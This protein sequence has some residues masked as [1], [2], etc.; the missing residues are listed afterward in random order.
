VKHAICRVCLAFAASMIPPGPLGAKR[1]QSRDGNDRD[2]S[3]EDANQLLAHALSDS[4][5]RDAL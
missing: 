4:I 3:R 2:L 1:F 5:A